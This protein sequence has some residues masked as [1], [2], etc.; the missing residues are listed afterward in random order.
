MIDGDHSGGQ[1]NFQNAEDLSDEDK[2][3]N[4]NRQAQKYN[5]IYDDPEG[6][7]VGYPGGGDWVNNLPY[8][9][10]GGGSVGDRPTLSILEFFVTPFDDLIWNSETDSQPSQLFPGKIIGIQLAMPDFDTAPQEYRGYH[11]LSG[12]ALTFRFAERFV[13][14]RLV[15][16]ENSSAVEAVS[17]AR[18]KS[19]F[20]D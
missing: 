12:Q 14:A 17:W 20:K 10:A 9:D 11:T 8:T 5:G 16:D 3:L 2:R 13:D 1:Y 4:F 19:S 15:G 18:I 6:R 7:F